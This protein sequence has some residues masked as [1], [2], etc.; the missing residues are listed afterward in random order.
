[1]V[2][3]LVQWGSLIVALLVLLWVDLRFFARDREPGFR[4]AV[5]WSIG[6]LVLSLLVAIPLWVLQSGPAAVDY[7]TVYLIERSLSLDNLFVFLIIFAYFGVPTR[8]RPRLVFWGIVFA[9]LLRGAA[10][11]AG[12]ALIEN[13]HFLIYVLA[14]GLLY[15]AYRVFR[16]MTEDIDPS[17]NLIVRGVRKLYPVTP[18]P[19]GDRW[20]V[21]REGQRF[22]TPVFLAL[23]ALIFTDLIFA[24]DSIPAALAITLDPFII[25]MGNVFALLG[26][27]ALFVLV[28]KLVARFRY[29]D[30]AI[31]V[32]LGFVAIKILL[33]AVHVEIP[34]LASLGVVVGILIAG[35][36][37][38]VAAERRAA[39]G[40]N[41][42]K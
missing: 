34:N 10:I 30:Q 16:G 6:W 14:A 17:N 8:S 37:V 28:E 26:L 5:V 20:F 35:M 23:A 22:V 42:G 2:S 19:V 15:L 11:G 18:E 4:E 36:L 7:V 21:Q 27:R 13:L 1:M 9:L 33:E 24:V 25:W 29:L 40:R 38:S 41:D 31:A 12:V 32:V 3:D 39:S